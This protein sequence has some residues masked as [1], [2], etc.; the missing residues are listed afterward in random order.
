MIFEKKEAAANKLLMQHFEIIGKVLEE[1]EKMIK[2]YMKNE[3][4]FKEQAYRIHTQEHE[5]DLLR[6]DIRV[7]LTE[8]A[9]LPVYREDYLRLADH[10]DKI[11]NRAEDVGDYLVLTRPRIPDFLREDLARMVE[12]TRQAY[13]PLINAMTTLDDDLDRIG[14]IRE[15]VAEGEQSV[16]RMLWDMTKHLF[17]SD[18]DLAQKLHVKGLLD[19]VAEL[20]NRIEDVADHF[21]IMLIKRKF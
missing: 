8:G 11:A 7:K 20:S 15:E 12:R 18:L 4:L 1:F 6:R 16:D 19:R 2:Y 10:V 13:E 17:K 9:F 14:R 5:A 21:E 3:K